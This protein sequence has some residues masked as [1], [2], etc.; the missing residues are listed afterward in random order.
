MSRTNSNARSLSLPRLCRGTKSR[1]R[2]RSGPAFG[3]A[4]RAGFGA[5]FV[6]PFGT[7]FTHGG[8]IMPIAP[9]GFQRAPHGARGPT[10]SPS[11]SLASGRIS[12]AIAGGRRAR[13]CR[14]LPRLD[15]FFDFV[16]VQQPLESV[17][18]QQAPCSSLRF[19]SASR[20]PAISSR[21]RSPGTTWRMTK[22]NAGLAAATWGA[23]RRVPSASISAAL[24]WRIL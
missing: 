4:S 2:A 1:L 6:G 7:A 16:G 22:T 5:S 18:P 23:H 13:S 12:L 9:G 11:W 20:G 15:E 3:A 14:A 10:I 21:S 17:A 8:N 19:V 24:D